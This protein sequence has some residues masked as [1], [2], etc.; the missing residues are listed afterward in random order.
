MK[1]IL[2]LF[3]ILISLAACKHSE[4]ELVSS[5]YYYTCSMHPQIVENKPGY[6]PICHMALI[7]VKKTQTA[8]NE[9]ALND[10]Q[11][12]LAN[13]LVDTLTN[14]QVGNKNV[15]TG[16]LTEDET[17]TVG[18]ATWISGRIDRLYFRSTGEYVTKGAPLFSIFSEELRNAQQEYLAA[19]EKKKS[20]DNTIVD[21]DRIIEGAAQKLQ[22]MGL[23]RGQIESLRSEGK[24]PGLTTYYSP[25]S[26]TLI[27]LP[28]K[29]GDYVQEGA[30]VA[31]VADYSSLWVQ[32]QAYA[33]Q[34]P[35]MVAG[36]SVR[37]E[38]AD[39]PGVKLSG[40]IAMVSP[41][42]IPDTR[43]TPIRIEVPNKNGQL[44][45]GM[46]A[47]VV[48]AQRV[49]ETP[50]LPVD[51][52]I[53]NGKKNIIWV[54]VSKNNFMWKEV[55]LGD[56]SNHQVAI[57]S[58]LKPGD[59]VVLSGAYLLNSEYLLKKGMTAMPDMPDMQ[60]MDMSKHGH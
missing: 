10:E 45:P 33:S 25:A 9:I 43:L 21:F 26:G 13:I 7:K 2:I 58:G 37:V 27:E 1:R 18:V 42:I 49:S 11:V 19:V 23:S 22:T 56:E 54:E 14:G 15:L 44:R 38:L 52:I 12:R 31:R 6:C 39:L 16:I 30:L 40:K 17:K 3:A 59:R 20:L 57:L 32:A 46:A 24:A 8:P 4:P 48:P 36:E 50:V 29:E 28:L 47:Y 53:R 5:D 35:S 41:E 60:G 34:L 51:A 55:T